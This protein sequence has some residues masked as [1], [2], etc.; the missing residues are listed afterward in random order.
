MSFE[1]K[2][3]TDFEGKEIEIIEEMITKPPEET[4]KIWSKEL[5]QNTIIE[6]TEQ[7]VTLEERIAVL[8]EQL[9]KFKKG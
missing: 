8:T 5:L 6:L 9:S 4:R 3:Q 7:I 1:L 2:T